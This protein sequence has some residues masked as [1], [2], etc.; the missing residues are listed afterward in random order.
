VAPPVATPVESPRKIESPRAMRYSPPPVRR[1]AQ[2]LARDLEE[3]EPE[4]PSTTEGSALGFDA[5]QERLRRLF[6]KTDA[7]EP[8]PESEEPMSL[9]TPTN[10]QG[11]S[12]GPRP[13]G[14][15]W[16]GSETQSAS[17]SRETRPGSDPASH[18][19][20]RTTEPLPREAEPAPSDWH[21]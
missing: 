12:E 7:V 8:P 5:E 20:P 10:L 11:W 4:L 9:E 14:I 6:P 1:D 3:I 15:E 18:E 19:T 17:A 16:G 2:P 13:A 21:A